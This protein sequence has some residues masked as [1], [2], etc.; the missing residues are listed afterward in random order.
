MGLDLLLSKLHFVEDPYSQFPLQLSTE[1]SVYITKLEFHTSNLA[2][3]S[4]QSLFGHG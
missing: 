4:S 3:Q 2:F 1:L